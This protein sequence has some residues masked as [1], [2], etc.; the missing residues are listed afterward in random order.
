M[1]TRR[2][3]GFWAHRV[4]LWVCRFSIG[5]VYLVAALGKLRDPVKFMGAMSDYRLLP[6]SVLPL[7]AAGM[8]GVELVVALC[9]L[10]G[11]RVRAAA[12]LA[13]TLMLIFMAAIA[14]AMARGLDLD[15]SC[16]D[17]LGVSS[18]VGWGV[19]GRD[20]LL[21]LPCLPLLKKKEPDAL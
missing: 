18:R 19:L 9:L 4:T 3:N 13:T 20:A 15:C 2:W 7:G 6:A 8:P 21:L 11:I 12:M 5:A 16:F 10:G 17:L 1:V 14:S